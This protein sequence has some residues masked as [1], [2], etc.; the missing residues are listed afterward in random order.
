MSTAEKQEKIAA[1]SGIHAVQVLKEA[2]EK[3]ID[4]ST[5]ASNG[6]VSNSSSDDEQTAKHEGNALPAEA[7]EVTVS[8]E[9][10]N[11]QA[12][13]AKESN[14]DAEA[15]DP[16]QIIQLFGDGSFIS[17]LSA[18]L[19]AETV[20]TP[21]D[22]PTETKID[23]AGAADEPEK[24]DEALAPIQILQLFGDGSLVMVPSET[25]VEEPA[26]LPSQVS[27]DTKI[28][29]KAFA[30]LCKGLQTGQ[31]AEALV[32]AQISASV[33][34]I[35]QVCADGSAAPKKLPV[36]HSMSVWN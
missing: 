2:A 11:E 3:E 27:N 14:E 35:A 26:S 24:D 31:L 7:D 32:L 25:L 34:E 30:D 33:Q 15:A 36:S 16:I 22:A 23:N 4:A 12:M 9:S 18:P 5:D 13:P 10:T 19:I 29:E 20:S 21:R 17:A 1:G 8:Q 28:M 6:D